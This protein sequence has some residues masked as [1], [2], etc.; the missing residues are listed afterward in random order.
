MVNSFGDL[1]QLGPVDAKE[2]HVMP[3]ENSTPDQLKGYAVYR[4]FNQCVVLTETLRQRS[5]QRK[6]LDR[7]LRIQIGE[8]IQ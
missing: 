2:L 3:G 5:D 7:L 6:L 8:I 1:G 4:S